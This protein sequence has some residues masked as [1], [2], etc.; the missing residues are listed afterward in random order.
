MWHPFSR[1]RLHLLRAL[2]GVGELD[3]EPV[4]EQRCWTQPAAQVLTDARAAVATA[5]ANGQT[6]LD[7]DLLAGLRARYD[8]AVAWGM[9]TNQ[10]RDW[11]TGRHPG[12]N[13]AKRLQ[14]RAVQVW[15]FTQDFA[16]PFINN[17]CEQ[18]PA[19]GRTPDEDRR[20]LAQCAHR[21]TLLPGPFL[22][23]HRPQPSIPSMPSATRWPQAHGCRHKPPDQS[24]V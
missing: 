23:D 6:A 8:A 19:H 16:V 10:H 2:C 18:P 14:T 21:G 4:R 1:M 24:R 15:R 11:P 12:Y 5:K 9:L 17:P 13:L 7:P 20:L 22:P 3:T